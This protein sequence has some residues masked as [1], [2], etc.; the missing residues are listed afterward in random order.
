[1]SEH[2]PLGQRANAHAA[3]PLLRLPLAAGEHGLHQILPVRQG[4]KTGCRQPPSTSAP[5]GQCST[6]NAA[7][8]RSWKSFRPGR[9]LPVAMCT[10]QPPAY[11]KMVDLGQRRISPRAYAVSVFYVIRHVT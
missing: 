1:M 3:S 11:A 5:S 4:V 7:C 6:T 2:V 8:E 10:T 9:A